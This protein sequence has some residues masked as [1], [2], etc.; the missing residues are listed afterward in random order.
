MIEIRK[1]DVAVIGGGIAGASVA[2]FLAEEGLLVGL[3]EAESTLA[4]HTTGRS[5]ALLTPNYGPDSM[6]AFAA[7]GRSFF[8]SPPIEVEHPLTTPK[9][10]IAIVDEEQAPWVERPP[11]SSWLSENEC[12]ERIPFLKKNKFV[13]AVVDSSVASIDVHALHS[14][15]LKIFTSRGGQIFKS[16]PISE[17]SQNLSGTWTLHIGEHRY[18]AASVVNAA[19]AW[20]DNIALRA[21]L[22]PVGLVPKRRTVIVVKDDQFDGV[23]SEGLPFV[24]VEPEYVYFQEF[25]TGQMIISPADKTPSAPCDAQADEY[26]IAVTVARFEEV[27]ELQIKRIDHSWAGLRTFTPDG[28]PVVGWEPNIEGFFWLVGQGGYGVFSSPALGRYAASVISGASLP[29]SYSE[30]GYDFEQLSPDR[31][32]LI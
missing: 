21:G 6:R 4:Y 22:N 19:G 16:A 29:V 32:R 7:I 30:S 26:D 17:L 15:Y 25:G 1:L 31:F 18:E 23:S 27:T 10:F 5:A 12:L 14:L 28:Q 11:E 13:G 8:D 2:A 9:D 3:F 24:A 20:G